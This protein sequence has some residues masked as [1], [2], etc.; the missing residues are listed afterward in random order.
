MI[1]NNELRYW[2]LVVMLF[3]SGMFVLGF[4]GGNKYCEQHQVNNY[5]QVSVEKVEV[6]VGDQKIVEQL[7]QCRKDLVEIS[8]A[9]NSNINCHDKMCK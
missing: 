9:F 4:W 8:E 5:C 3:S 2:S 7:I 6:P 1:T